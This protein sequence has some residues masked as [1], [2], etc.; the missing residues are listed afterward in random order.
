[1]VEY[2][3]T[4]QIPSGVI[5]MWKGSIAT[6]PKGWVFCDGNNGTPDLRDLFIV[7]ASVDEA[8]TAKTTYGNTLAT[9]GKLQ[10]TGKFS[11]SNAYLINI[12][13]IEQDQDMLAIPSNQTASM[14]TPVPAFYALAYIMKL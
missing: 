11:G 10:T 14:T 12:G 2:D 4:Y 7:G 8:G 3:L 5:C 9:N 6:I 13:V 1:M